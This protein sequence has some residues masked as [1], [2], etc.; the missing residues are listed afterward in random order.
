M[1]RIPMILIEDATNC[2]A[3]ITETPFIKDNFSFVWLNIDDE[4]DFIYISGFDGLTTDDYYDFYYDYFSD[5]HQKSKIVSTLSKKYKW[6]DKK[7]YLQ[8]NSIIVFDLGYSGV[9]K[10]RKDAAKKS[11]EELVQGFKKQ[12]S[13][14]IDLDPEQYLGLHLIQVALQNKNWKGVICTATTINKPYHIEEFLYQMIYHYQRSNDV[15]LVCLEESVSVWISAKYDV[16]EKVIRKITS[17]YIK[18]FGTFENRICN[19]PELGNW[20]NLKGNY[21]PEPKISHN[22]S[23]FFEQK[24]I[25]Q[26]KM[27]QNYIHNLLRFEFLGADSLFGQNKENIFLL[28]FETVKDMVYPKKNLTLFHVVLSLMIGQQKLGN[29]WIFSFFENLNYNVCLNKKYKKLNYKKLH[30]LLDET[31]MHK[32]KS[33]EEAKQLKFETLN[34]FHR[35]GEELKTEDAS[36]TV[37]EQVQLNNGNC[38]R[39]FL[40]FDATEL[41]KKYESDNGGAILNSIRKCEDVLAFSIDDEDKKWFLEFSKCQI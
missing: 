41:K 22:F 31:R 14:F 15:E 24:N 27:F 26:Q 6:I 17:E 33:D 19:T 13:A 18:R 40:N 28:L 4:E 10:E 36:S 1:I 35:L 20:F 9:S 2:S 11:I 5:N 30:Y 29:G 21:T 23:E 16:Q 38:V 12:S 37:I 34:K 7:K 3:L 32:L 25:I 8:G 39:I